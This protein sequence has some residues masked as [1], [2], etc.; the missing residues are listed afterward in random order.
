MMLNRK[1]LVLNQNYEPFLI[2]SAKRAIVLAYLHKAVIIEKYQGEVHSVSL[3]MPCPSV[4]RLNRYAHKPYKEVQLNRRNILKRDKH[5]CQYC[6]K[7]SRAMTVDHIIP[8][9]YG[10]AE[11]WENLVCACLTCNSKKGNQ[12]AEEAGLKLIKKPK[13]PS[14]LF[15]LQNLIGRPPKS[16]NP[17]LFLN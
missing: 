17:Y 11:T 12:R 14:H 1:V 7:N 10:G 8:K 5:I 9:S 16:W 13:K 6:G 2:C 3:S 4:I 15:Y